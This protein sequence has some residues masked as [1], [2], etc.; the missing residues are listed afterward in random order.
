VIKLDWGDSFAIGTILAFVTYVGGAIIFY[1]RPWSFIVLGLTLVS[2]G[3]V[4][5]LGR[6]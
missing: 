3:L 2:T 4:H 5:R 6:G 1:A